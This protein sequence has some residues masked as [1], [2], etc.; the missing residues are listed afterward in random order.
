MLKNGKKRIYENKINKMLYRIVLFTLISVLISSLISC[1]GKVIDSKSSSVHPSIATSSTQ[2]T[3]KT[4]QQILNGMAIGEKGT[5]INI[6][7]I[8]SAIGKDEDKKPAKSGETYYYV[9]ITI[10]N[11]GTLVHDMSI[12]QRFHL[13]N[14][15][16]EKVYIESFITVDG[17]DMNGAKLATGESVTGRALFSVPE[18]F[19]VMAFTYTF[20]INGFGIFTYLAK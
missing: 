2:S 15:S 16:R 18:N 14:A 19:A 1:Q 10:K 8:V 6:E 3:S 13:L 17:R 12:S 5:S 4:S 20:D 7:T 11:I 9:E